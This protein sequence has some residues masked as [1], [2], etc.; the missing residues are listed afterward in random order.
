L[1]LRQCTRASEFTCPQAD[2]LAT[3]CKETGQRLTHPFRLENGVSQTKPC[4]MCQHIT[5]VQCMAYC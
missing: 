3:I 5:R 2:R 4:S 1:P